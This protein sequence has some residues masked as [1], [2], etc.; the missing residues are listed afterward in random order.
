MTNKSLQNSSMYKLL[1]GRKNAVVKVLCGEL[2]K[3]ENQVGQILEYAKVNFPNFT[4]H[5]LQH[6]L[7]IIDYVYAIMSDT[8]KN[9]ISDMEIFCFIMAVLFHDTGMTLSSVDNKD[10]QRYAHH[11]YAETPIKEYCENYLRAISEYRRVCTCI[12]FVCKAHGYKIADLYSDSQFIKEDFIEGQIIRYGLLAVLLRIG[13]L[14][15]MEEGR[16]SEFNLHLN[17]A[18]YD[19]GNSMEHNKRHLEIEAYKYDSE[20]IKIEIATGNRERYVIWREWIKYLDV[21]IMQANTH[22][23]PKI[24][25]QKI[26]YKL[27]GVNVDIKPGEG[28]NFIVEEIKFEVDDK[29]TLWSILT[30]SI[31]TNE[32]DYLRELIQNAIDANLM[33]YFIAEEGNIKETSPRKWNVKDDVRIFYSEKANLL[34]VIDH[35]IG[36]N[37]LEMRKYL[38]K[39]A[40]S[41]YRYKKVCGNFS[42]PA[43]AKFG[44]GFISC[45]VKAEKMEITSQASC[46]KR[47]YAYTQKDSNTVFLETS[48][49]DPKIGTIVLLKTK[50]R[51]LFKEIEDYFNSTFIYPSVNLRLI[52]LDS[53]IQND[54]KMSYFNLELNQMDTVKNWLQIDEKLEPFAKERAKIIERY[55]L[56]L[57]LH[58][59]I[60]TALGDKDDV[61]E[62]IKTIDIML[63]VVSH[64]SIVKRK[65]SQFFSCHDKTK[66]EMKD[67]KKILLQCQDENKEKLSEYPFIERTKK[68]EKMEDIR[69]YEVM[70]IELDEDFKISQIYTDN[71]V[72]NLNRGLG[73]LSIRTSIM[74]TQ[75]G[76]EWQTVN[77][78]LYN[79]GQIVKNILKATHTRED[80]EINNSDIISLDDLKDA[81]Y[82]MNLRYEEDNDVS[83]YER[84]TQW[85][86]SDNRE[87]Y[88]MEKTYLY[89]IVSVADNNFWIDYNVSVCDKS[90]SLSYD[91]L[92][93]HGL[94]LDS[95]RMPENYNGDILS[96]GSSLLCQD[97]IRLEVNPHIAVPVGI[98]WT[99]ANLTASARLDLNVSRHEINMSRESV[100]EWVRNTGD[101]IQQQV[102]AHCLQVFK[103]LGLKYELSDLFYVDC[104][105]DYF[106]NILFKNMKKI[107]EEK[108]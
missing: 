60:F 9:E 81:D 75:I 89:N 21:E 76:L 84:E 100:D 5:G 41:G 1:E 6:S 63:K 35:G 4:E 36:M 22:Y 78:F 88:Y 46:E 65:W 102:A 24:D 99:V 12:V 83:F 26:G 32:F 14:M 31:Y 73:I 105:D 71:K 62:W 74:D 77:A 47:V 70:S 11:L 7:R 90:E 93:S 30:N 42:F 85:K 54:L 96:I 87:Q 28:A 92:D 58:R 80:V 103:R 55:I 18:Y 45:L 25:K 106:E 17:G 82:E 79:E 50:S 19:I 29:G 33:K 94:L 56:D 57:D 101:K 72:R 20:E 43:I 66:A 86:N 39:A 16:T 98:G 44:I 38:F 3:M 52:N 27:P 67:I 108:Q 51:Y 8:L 91:N 97:G 59:E 34:A 61:N 49:C 40:D 107:I 69:S 68:N 10:E 95:Y 53:L 2:L 64:D 15:D 37:E 23:L 104:P 13:D 48:E